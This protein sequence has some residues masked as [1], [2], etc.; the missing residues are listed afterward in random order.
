MAN[1]KRNRSATARRTGVSGA[2]Q[3]NGRPA[4]AAAPSE[5]VV[6]SVDSGRKD[7]GRTTAAPTRA[8]RAQRGG[9][10]PPAGRPPTSP[11]R[12]A[13][14]GARRQVWWRSPTTLIAAVVAIA[15]IVA[16]FAAVALNQNSNAGTSQADLPAVVAAVTQIDSAVSSAVGTGGL[17]QPLAATPPNTPILK[18]PTQKPQLLYIGAGYCPYCAAERWSVIVAL[19]RFGTFSDLHLA[20]SSGTD[21]Y[22]NT[23]TFTFYG[24]SYHSDYLD[25]VSVEETGQD[26]QS[27]LQ[28]PTAEQEQLFRTYDA[29]PYTNSP[30][31]IPFLDLAN[32]YITVS[33]GFSPQVLSGHSW[34]D[35]ATALA[36]PKAATTQAIV[37][38]AN[39]LTAALCRVTGNQPATACT[40]APIPELIQQLPAAK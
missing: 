8:G 17:P 37:G 40:V 23:P 16:G 9:G 39:Y 31:G 3:T 12:R 26:Q 6:G 25:F 33:S 13:A 1:T 29:A 10:P 34:K 32:Q 28:A 2:Q 7:D 5:R 27:H 35:I 20:Q 15:I 4:A 14:I 30:G 21:V 24:S 36:D 18:G 19:A 38:N 22:P 11:S